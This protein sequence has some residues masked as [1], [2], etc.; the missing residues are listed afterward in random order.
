MINT[1]PGSEDVRNLK[2]QEP[3][4]CG[5]QGKRKSSA[6]KIQRTPSLTVAVATGSP[7]FSSGN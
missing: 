4:L 1:P 2:S 5:C 3:Q 6:V 7:L